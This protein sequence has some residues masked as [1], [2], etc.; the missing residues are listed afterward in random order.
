MTL[1]EAA[2]IVGILEFN[3]PDTRRHQSDEAYITYI[4][5]WHSFFEHDS[6]ELVE[7]AVRAYIA[8][9][10]ERF[11]PNVGQIKEQ[12]R[13]LTAPEQMSEAEAWTRIK[14]ALSNGIYG[15]EEEYAKLPPVLQ[16]LVGSP[17][18]LREWAQMDADTVESVIG[19]NIQRSYRAIS[20]QEAEW[21][22]LPAGF[23]EHMQQL[24]GQIFGRLELEGGDDEGT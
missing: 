17:S 21:A 20:A 7:A 14:K 4:R 19:S 24:S 3:Y 18:R 12:I 16:R 23:R 1:E 9:S 2:K 5:N 15:A 10:T 22:K 6:F 8:T 11:M 13:K